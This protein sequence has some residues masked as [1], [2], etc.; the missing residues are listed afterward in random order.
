MTGDVFYE[1]DEPLE[2]V[3]RA[4]RNGRKVV[5]EAPHRA[6]DGRMGEDGWLT[7]DVCGSTWHPDGC[8]VHH[9][10]GARS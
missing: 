3:E 10:R 4:Y 7:Y 8:P 6:A 9:C 2:D 5:T 1:D